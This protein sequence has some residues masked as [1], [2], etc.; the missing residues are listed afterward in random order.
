AKAPE[1]LKKEAE[2]RP[3]S[4]EEELTLANRIFEKFLTEEVALRSLPPEG[5][6][7]LGPVDQWRWGLFHIRCCLVFGW[8]VCRGPR[9]FRGFVYYLYRYWICVRQSLG[10][11]IA[12]PP[13][14]EQ[15]RDFHALV[16]ALAGAYKPYLTD[17]LAS[18]EFPDGIPDEVL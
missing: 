12:T 15:R 13:T 6:Q 3:P 8:L 5:R 7:L 4:C 2:S 18:V 14:E 1:E 9:T 16:Q 11:P 17:Q 10:D